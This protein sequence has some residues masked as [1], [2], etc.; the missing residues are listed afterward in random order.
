MKL[1]PL[2]IMILLLLSGQAMATFCQNDPVN[3][4]DPL[5]LAGYFFGGTGN[6]LD[7]GQESNVEILYRAWNVAQN[8]NRHYVPGV[9]SGRDPDGKITS[10]KWYY[11]WLSRGQ[12]S[13]GAAGRTLGARA[14]KM[15]EHLETE[16]AAGDKE[17]NL[18]GF[19][20]GSTTAL[21]F[22][23]R[24]RENMLNPAKSKLY[25]GIRIKF[26]ALWDTV[27]TTIASYRTELPK[28][29]KFEHKPLHFIAL[30]EQRA[31]FFDNDVLNIEGALQIGY[32][33]V[34]ADTGGFIYPDKENAFGW[35]SRQDAVSAA[36]QIGINFDAETLAHYSSHRDWS[37]IPTDND[38]IIYNGGETRTFPSDMYLSP[39]VF[40]FGRYTKPYNPISNQHR[41]IMTRDWYRWAGKTY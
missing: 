19:S 32:R 40:E 26:V 41:T 15:I 36:F 17:V 16:L 8:G 20:R 11:L 35:I 9:M 21:V 27:D 5:G 30:D 6:S 25:E 37:A 10:R 31:Q 38:L 14:A 7:K 1:T 34:H 2:T 4:V 33:G 13:E 28:G 12:I 23:N 3:A 39:S 22:L 24:I 29:M 18:F